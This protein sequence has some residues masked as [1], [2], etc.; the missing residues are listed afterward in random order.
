MVV[1][2]YDC[3]IQLSKYNFPINVSV[4]HYFI[5]F[6]GVQAQYYI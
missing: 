4:Y 1:E 6:Y 5:Q 2:N 3:Y